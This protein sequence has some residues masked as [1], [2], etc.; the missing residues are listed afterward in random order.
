MLKNEKLAFFEKT[1]ERFLLLQKMKGIEEDR[2]EPGER[3]NKIPVSFIQESIITSVNYFR[4]PV[5]PFGFTI[6]GNLSIPV[7]CKTVKEIMRR[8]EVLRTNFEVIGNKY[9]Q[10]INDVPD[11]FINIVD[12]QNLSKI[13]KTDESNRIVLTRA[14]D[15][16]DFFKDKLMIMVML[17][18]TGDTEHN[19]CIYMDHIITD[20][21]SSDLFT[22]ELA[23]LY[24]L[25][26]L[27]QP[28]PFA[29]LPIQ[30]ADY[31]IWEQ[32]RYSGELLEEKLDYWKKHLSQKIDTT[33]PRDDTGPTELSGGGVVQ[34]FIDL[35]LTKNLK[36]LS[37]KN[38]VSLFTTMLAAFASLIH[39]FSGYKYNYFTFSVANRFQKEIESLIGCFMNTQ[40]VHLDLEG[41]LSFQD[42][43]KRAN[44]TL[45]DVYEN[46][47]PYTFIKR[48]HQIKSQAVNF[49]LNSS[50]EITMKNLKVKSKE[51]EVIPF[52]IPRP[53]LGLLPIHVVLTENSGTIGGL[54]TYRKNIYRYS[55]IE[56]LKNDF[57]N[58]LKAIV[59]NP[60]IRISEID[61]IPHESMSA[62]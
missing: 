6:K 19:L 3:G 43:I 27:N 14:S 10:T 26:S 35:E 4:T 46:F 37:Q 39:I 38:N 62:Y 5:I 12:L 22:N 17:I 44:E 61:M 2:I 33:L 34:V 13:E 16:F 1:K 57:I 45:M 50:S 49:Q 52:R 31:A 56:K 15:K 42:I 29:E 24:R 54:F 59:N 30:Y 28:S 25:F 41:D 55:T 21:W 53:V 36:L 40:S 9:Y 23:I 60:R 47:V 20:A 58:L 8:H 48:I 18:K 11:K 7:L 51:M 32:K